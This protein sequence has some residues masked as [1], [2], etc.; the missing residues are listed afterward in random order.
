M[1]KLEN[2]PLD[3]R[4]QDLNLRRGVLT[5]KDIEKHL[6]DLPD[7]S[8]HAE[9]LIVYEEE[10]EATGKEASGTGDPSTE[11][12]ETTGET[13]AETADSDLTSTEPS[14]WGEKTS[15]S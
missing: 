9:E 10:E 8:E 6:K 12:L 2:T 1:P 5:R 3:V 7:D 4:L 14:P 15:S 11:T 13:T